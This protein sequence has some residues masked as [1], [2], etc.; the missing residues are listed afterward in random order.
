MTKISGVLLHRPYEHGGTIGGY[1]TG[2]CIADSYAVD[3]SDYTVLDLIDSASIVAAGGFA[4]SQAITADKGFGINSD[5]PS[6]GGAYVS[7]PAN[8]YQTTANTTNP[9]VPGWFDTASKTFVKPSTWSI[10]RH[11]WYSAARRSVE[12][13]ARHSHSSVA[14][15]H[16]ELLKLGSWISVYWLG[17]VR[18][19]PDGPSEVDGRPVLQ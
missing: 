17:L 7:S 19:C 15:E 11:V 12:R 3:V 13:Q 18:P 2:E 6:A 10:Y 9:V 4:S 16:C 14:S 5:I 1:A 8:G